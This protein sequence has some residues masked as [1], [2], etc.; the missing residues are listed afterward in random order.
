MYA[1]NVFDQLRTVFP[2]TAAADDSGALTLGGLS[3]TTLAEQ[4]GTPLLVIDEQTV[5]DNARRWCDALASWEPG[6][7]V[8]FACKSLCTVDVLRMTARNGLGADVASAGELAIALLAGIAPAG[9]VVHGNN[10]SREHIQ[11]AVAAGVGLI[12]VDAPDE[13]D[14]IVDAVKTTGM[15]PQQVLVRV[16]PDIE[17]ETHRY[18][19]T[20]HAGSKFGV[21]S[22]LAQT[23]LRRA[24][25]VPELDPAG[26]HVHLGSQLLDITPWHDV[27]N[28]LGPFARELADQGTPIR[29]LDVGG[30]LG[31]AYV[32]QQAPP[33][34]ESVAEIT[35]AE[36]RHAWQL[37]ACGELPQLIVEPGRSVIGRAGVTLYRVGVVKDDGPIGYVNVDGGM[38]DNP[39]PMLYQSEY[40]CVLANRVTDQPTGSW[41]IA[42]SHCESGDVLIEDAPLPDPRRGDLLAVP[43]T[44]AYTLSMSSN[45]NAIPRPAIVVVHDGESRTVVRRE[46]IADLLARD[47]GVSR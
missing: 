14:L 13:L 42:G 29:V 1:V 34:I 5:A 17:V 43:A 30:G 16:N 11:D 40:S 39:R 44:G 24:L 9:L 3:C 28:W 25:A 2:T 10:K 35:M 31:I 15:P 18:I 33:T 36:I 23:M 38:S 20:G 21:S 7:R 46:T 45:Y 8:V 41:W 32:A 19:R 22:Q 37:N 4:H 6:A 26:I 12:V 27:L 47:E